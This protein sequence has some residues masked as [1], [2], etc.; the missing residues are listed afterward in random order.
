MI[1]IRN[2]NYVCLVSGTFSGTYK[3]LSVVVEYTCA[4]FLVCPSVMPLS[5]YDFSCNSSGMWE[6]GLNQHFHRDVADAGLTTPNRTECSFCVAPDHPLLAAIPLPYDDVTHCVGMSV[7]NTIIQAGLYYS[8]GEKST[9]MM[10]RVHVPL[11]DIYTIH[12][13]TMQNRCTMI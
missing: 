6:D 11:Y 12:Y 3:I 7:C 4:G 2:I 8:V 5:Q 13:K 9:T 1:T 10:P